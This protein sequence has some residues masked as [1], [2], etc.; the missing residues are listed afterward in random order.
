VCIDNLRSMLAEC[1][2]G[3][4]VVE[5]IKRRAEYVQCA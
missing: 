2:F 5:L 1:Q 4:T 3:K